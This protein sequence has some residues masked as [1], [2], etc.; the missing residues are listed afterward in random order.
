MPICEK[1]GKEHDGSYGSGRFC[2]ARCAREYSKTFITEEGRAN[3]IKALTDKENKRKSIEARK[4]KQYKEP[5]KKEKRYTGIS[6][7][8]IGT[9]GELET[10]RIDKLKDSVD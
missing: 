10:M 7:K 4:L 2:C 9:I 8:K 6:S 1:C 5:I 3:Q